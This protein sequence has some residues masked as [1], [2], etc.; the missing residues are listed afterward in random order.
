MIADEDDLNAGETEETATGSEGTEGSAATQTS[1]VA[2]P[3]GKAT[4]GQPSGEGKPGAG[5]TIAGGA[6]EGEAEPKGKAYW[7]TDWRQK[8]ADY[9][10]AGDKKEAAR[11]LKQLDRYVDPAAIFGKAREL[12][13]KFSAGGLLKVPAKDAK[14][15]E[16]EAF[17]K[18]LGVPEKPEDYLNEVKLDNGATIGDAD[19]PGLTTF[20]EAM[21]KVGAA[22]ESVNAALNWYYQEQERI[23]ADQED[24]DEEFKSKSIETLKEE[25]GPAF[26]REI[27]LTASLFAEMPGGSNQ[28]NENSFYA[29][30]IGGRMADGTR[31]GDNPDF[32]RWLISLRRDVNPAASVVE[33]GRN[34]GQ[35]LDEEIKKIEEIMRTD[36]PRYNKE[37]AT[38]YGELLTAREKIQA[39]QRA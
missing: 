11:L 5:K 31:I 26:K 4:E 29:K 22:P 28:K 25:L 37:Y 19:K 24:R 8:M 12:E 3:E 32:M 13:S 16:V 18:A 38:R 27:N 35:S 23:A 39:R 15:E 7:P 6:E 2:S 30:L 10:S 14:A 34:T 20:A 36:R 21:H 9:A 33:D 1:P 17:R